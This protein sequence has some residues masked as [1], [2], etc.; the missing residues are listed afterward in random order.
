MTTKAE[1]AAQ[2]FADFRADIERKIAQY[3]RTIIGVFPDHKTSDPNE[4]FVYS[5][6]N[7]LKGYPELLLI[8]FAQE[9]R[10][11]NVLSDRMLQRGHR[12]HDGELIDLG[13]IVPLCVVAASEQVKQLFTIQASAYYAPE[14]AYEVMQ[15]VVPDKHGKFPWDPDCAHPFCDV[16]V[17]RKLQA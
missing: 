10:L 16:T 5:I 6:G 4:A 2:A 1:R 13:G 14:L 7:A 8:G 15:V 11:L 17:Y 12:F 3:G 9:H